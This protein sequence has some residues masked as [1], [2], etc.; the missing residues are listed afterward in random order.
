MTNIWGRKSVFFVSQIL[1]ECISASFYRLSSFEIYVRHQMWNFWKTDKFL[2]FLVYLNQKWHF[3]LIC[4]IYIKYIYQNGHYGKMKLPNFKNFFF[5][6]FVNIYAFNLAQWSVAKYCLKSYFWPFLWA[7]I[8]F[9]S[10]IGK[11]GQKSF[12]IGTV[13]GISWVIGEWKSY[14]RGSK[15]ISPSF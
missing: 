4:R 11:N 8:A 7:K 15:L 3:C 14:A 1:N 5:W 2:S 6:N 13:N 9:F 10:K 12:L